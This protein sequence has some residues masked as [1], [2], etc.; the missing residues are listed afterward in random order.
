VQIREVIK[1]ATPEQQRVNQL[2]FQL[3]AARR[4]ATQARLNQ[5]QVRI[6][7]QRQKLNQ[8]PQ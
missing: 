7:Q 6:L 3:D 4:A 2:K 8:T 1:P 5:Q